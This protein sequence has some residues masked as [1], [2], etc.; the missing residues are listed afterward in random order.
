MHGGKTPQVA[1]AARRRIM[2]A[3]DPAA[4]KLVAL[5]DSADERVIFAVA[6]DL[7]DRAGYKP[8]TTVEVIT[9]SAMEA[10]YERLLAEN[11]AQ[12]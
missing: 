1:K 10:E 12:S 7:L 2:E 11:D 3:A 6:R 5:L 4:A 8:A 9:R